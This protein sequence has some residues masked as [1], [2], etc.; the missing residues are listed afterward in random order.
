MKLKLML[1]AAGL[2]FAMSGTALAAG[3]NYDLNDEY[4]GPDAWASLGYEECNGSAQSPIDLGSARDGEL[5][6]L[7]IDFNSVTLS[8]VVNNGHTIQV[9]VDN[10]STLTIKRKEYTLLQFHFHSPSEHAVDDYRYP[11]EIHFVTQAADGTLAVIGV[12]VEK[13][14]H[15]RTLQ[16][17][18]NLAP[19]EEGENG[20]S[21]SIRATRLIAG[22]NEEYF[23]YQ[24]SL[25]TPPCS[26]IV[27]WNVMGKSIEASEEQINFFI[28]LLHEGH[29]ARPV[30][31]V[32]GRKVIEGDD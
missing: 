11:M 21:D 6:A 2:S 29:N 24:G 4:Y 5:P 31:P 19:H 7:N 32:N 18:W 12:F 14:D 15:N 3:W 17:I 9:N 10:G 16:K 8:S 23:G 20:S 26:E 1:A 28:S 27:T 13:G 25:T 30:Q 22:D